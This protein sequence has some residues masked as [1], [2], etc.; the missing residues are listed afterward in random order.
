M[1]ER[2]MM[3]AIDALFEKD[4]FDFS[5]EHRMMFVK[6]FQECARLHYDGNS[7]FRAFW[8][9]AHL[10]PDGVQAERDLERV[11]PIMV[12]L[13]K[14]R[15]FVTGPR[16]RIVLTLT[17]SGTGGQKSQMLLD[18]DSLRR[19]KRL[20]WQIHQSLGIASDDKVNYLCFTYDPRIAANL[21]T[22]F[23]DELLTSFTKKNEVYYALQWNE[24]MGEFFLN[25]NGVLETLDRFSKDSHPTRI[26]GFPAH[27]YKIIRDHQFR[28][29]LGDRSWVQTGGGWKGLAD[30]EIPKA[31]FRRFIAERL[32]I[33]EGNIR[34]MF[35]MVEHGI[36]YCDCELG[37]LHVP[38]YSR[39]FVR[40]PGDLS[41]LPE[42]EIGLIHFLCSYNTSYPS[43]SLLTTDWGRLG[44]CRCGRGGQVLEICGRAGVAKHKGCA[45]AASKFL[46]GEESK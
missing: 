45:I 34:D 32:G 43:I 4:P 27:L 3:S 26:L 31:D 13:F 5:E 29:S 38:N 8:D 20:A 15:E 28:V 18:E 41:I 7:V 10:H 39:V 1:G 25:V 30:E 6:S 35:G 37:N 36:P 24:K 12:H 16:D 19:V 42:G 17:S 46:G 23:T 44:R 14:E 22:A 11:P 33:P 2:Q 21:G 40:S 9:D